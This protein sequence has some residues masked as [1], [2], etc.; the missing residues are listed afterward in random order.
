MEKNSLSKGFKMEESLRH[1]LIES[2]YYVVRG[3]P[4]QYKG[5]DITDVDLWLY[6][7]PSP[8][9]REISIVDI[10]NKKTPQAIERIFW[11]KGLQKSVSADKAIVATTDRR[12][13]V[14]EFGKTL[15]VFVLDGDFLSRLSNKK[16]KAPNTRL[17]DE[18]FYNLFDAYKFEK[19]DGDWK[20]RITKAKSHLID[21]DGLGFNSA[22][23][24]IKEAQFFGNQ[25]L[26]KDKQATLSARCL[27]LLCSF[28]AISIDY[29]LKDFAFLTTET[30]KKQLA[31]GFSFGDNGSESFKANLKT[32]TM[33]MTAFHENG[34]AIANQIEGN[35]EEELS[36]L[37][38]EPLA[39]FFSRPDVAKN[40]F[41]VGIELEALAYR[42]DFLSHTESSNELRAFVGCIL[43]YI[44]INRVYFNQQATRYV[45]KPPQQEL[46]L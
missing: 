34:T 8:I 1:Y 28:I 12:P 21:S 11:I 27:Y 25:T 16:E 4:F 13:E 3:V 35:I 39:E 10:K 43:D 20:R 38:T 24:W 45:N 44:G 30:R 46:N 37:K 41:S 2:G 7:R 23:H 14:K 19:L 15:D 18:E 31:E 22:L 17:T 42:K 40:L 9:S 32:A 26:I 29:L 6:A 5:F 36:S 33:L